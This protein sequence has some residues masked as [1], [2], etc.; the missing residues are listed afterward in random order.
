M[1]PTSTPLPI[2]VI[3][4]PTTI[5]RVRNPDA[6]AETPSTNCMNVGR[7]VK[8]PSM[9]KPTTKLST[10]QT[11]NTGSLNNRIGSTGSAARSSTLT[12]TVRASAEAANSP[13]MVGD[14]H[15]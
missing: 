8:A 14:H 15:A 6:V 2:E 1:R 7:K 13:M 12:K 9:A 10:Q 4:S 5:G 3:S 11:V